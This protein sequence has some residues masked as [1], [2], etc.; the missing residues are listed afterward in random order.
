MVRYALALVV[1]LGVA[2]ATPA[3]PWADALFDSLE[4]DFGAVPRGPTITHAFELTNNT[5]TPIHV[6]GLRV[7]CSCVSASLSQQTLQPGE[8]GTILAQMHT[9]R[10]AG[11]SVKPIYVLFDSPHSAEV[12]LTVRAVSRE[13][14]TLTPQSF[15]F[16]RVPHGSA[17]ET[18]VTALLLGPPDCKITGATSDSALIKPRVT[19]LRQPSGEV[20][21]QVTVCLPPELPAGNWFGTI[22]LITD[23]PALQRIA[24]PLIAEVV[25]S[26]TISPKRLALGPVKAGVEADRKVVVRSDRPF[27]ILEVTGT[28][29][30]VAVVDGKGGNA[31]VH[32]LQL[33]FR[34]TTPGDLTRTIRIRT[35]SKE[36][37]LVEFR[38]T[39]TI[40][41]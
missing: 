12:Q 26:L 6:A 1:G 30:E 32:V 9:N 7:P 18:T 40:L 8:R 36:E 29:T 14:V 28:D 24:I 15:D 35:D 17:P 11:Q 41:P 39:A 37:G 34:A 20:A 4:H 31:D 22:W 25:P 10:F 3:A 5:E 21:Y 16:R 27:R 19:P 13:D 38:V 33:K 23:N 2:T